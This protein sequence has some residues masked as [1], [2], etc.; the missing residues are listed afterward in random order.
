MG[1]AYPKVGDSLGLPQGGADCEP[2]PL[3]YLRERPQPDF[4]LGFL[5]GGSSD[6]TSTQR[7]R[8]AMTKINAKKPL[9]RTESRS[10]RNSVSIKHK[11]TERAAASSILPK[12]SAF[13]KKARIF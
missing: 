11:A 12:S 3:C 5:A 1:W 9:S 13:G 8:F 7:N 2:L 10:I 6:L 4:S